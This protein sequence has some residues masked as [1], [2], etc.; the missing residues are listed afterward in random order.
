MY[1]DTPIH[2]A[3][4]PQPALVL[5]CPT[6]WSMLGCQHEYWPGLLPAKILYL[7]AVDFGGNPNKVAT[8]A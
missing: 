5:L 1:L 3:A 2:K 6:A 8:F 4:V 7:L